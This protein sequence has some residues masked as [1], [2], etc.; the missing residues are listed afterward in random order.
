[1]AE[2]FCKFCG[3]PI[4]WV[5]TPAGRMIPLEDSSDQAKGTFVL[6]VVDLPDGTAKRMAVGLTRHERIEADADGE[7]L[8]QAHRAVCFPDRRGSAIP[9]AVRKQANQVIAQAQGKKK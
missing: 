6:R 7:L 3:A 9:P 8:F 5:R 2:H 1:M 4:R